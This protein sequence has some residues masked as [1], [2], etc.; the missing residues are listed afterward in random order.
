M[1]T[2]ISGFA[3]RFLNNM[4]TKDWF[5]AIIGAIIAVPLVWIIITLTIVAVG[6]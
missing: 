4:N 1:A 6:K 5:K 3:V 2:L